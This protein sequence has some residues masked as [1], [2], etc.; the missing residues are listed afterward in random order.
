VKTEQHSVGGIGISHR[1]LN[2]KILQRLHRR[3]QEKARCRKG[4]FGPPPRL[5]IQDDEAA[6]GK[7]LLSWKPPISDRARQMYQISNDPG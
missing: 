3:T 5:K 1:N 7:K 4:M 2:G 6:K